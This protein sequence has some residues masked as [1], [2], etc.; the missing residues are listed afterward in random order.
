MSSSRSIAAAR[1]RRS[2]DPTP[3]VSAQISR[4]NR[5]IGGQTSFVPPQQQPQL[6]RQ[7]QGQNS[8]VSQSQGKQIQEQTVVPVTKL[9]VSDAI[10]LITL[11]LGRLET[12]MYDVQA[13][14]YTNSGELPENTQLVDKSVMTS[15]INRVEHLEKEKPVSQQSSGVNTKL[16]SQLNSLEKEVKD[17]KEIL[18][19]HIMKYEKYL[20]HNES[21]MVSIEE[22]IVSI[23]NYLKNENIEEPNEELPLE[24]LP[25]EDLHDEELPNEDTSLENRISEESVSVDLKQAIQKELANN[26]F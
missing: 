11:R 19:T 25:D 21:R 2:G 3:P 24:D 18:L 23:D 13:G 1:N 16:T 4:P 14:V 15:I 7:G 9:S 8:Y 12:F 10:G 20:I 6:K 17:L 26:I 5:S 22:N